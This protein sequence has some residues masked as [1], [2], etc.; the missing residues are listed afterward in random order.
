M[1]RSDETPKIPGLDIVIRRRGV[2]GLG[3]ALT[4][5]GAGRAAA[6][7]NVKVGAVLPLAGA[8]AASGQDMLHG[9]QLAIADI[10]GAGGIKAIGGRKLELTVGDAGQSPESAVQTARRVLNAEPVACI[11]SWYSS[12]TLAATQVA[13]QK[14]IPWLTGSVADAIT[15]RGFKYAF[16]ISAG[17]EASAQG[18]IDAIKK[19]SSGGESRLV[20]LTDN[21]AASVDIKG[22]IRKMITTPVVSDQTWTP[23]L[24]DATPAVSAAL[25]E[26][27]TVIYLGATSTSDQALVI[28][29]LAAQGN[30]APII[31]GASSGANPIFLEAVGGEAME[32]VVVVTGVAFPGKGTDELNRK[33]A[34]LSQKPFMDCEAFTGYVNVHIVAQA[35]EAAGKAEAAAVREALAGMDARDRPVLSLLP[36][37]NRLQFGPNGRRLGSLVELLQWQGGQPRVV[38]P[39]ELASAELK[40]RS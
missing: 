16:A 17:S 31:M 2:L 38:F 6:E 12:L 33:Y 7:E 25:R 3:V 13:E 35:L 8:F 29:Q 20:L 40:T 24:A 27:P 22:F 4:A 34:A 15:G 23:P 19:L 18:L 26:K 36:N 39:P 5:A 10:N 28:K 11:G 9:A 14:K 30:T 32:G 1:R 21:N 37:G